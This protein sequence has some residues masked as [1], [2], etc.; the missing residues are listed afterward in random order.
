MVS[1]GVA[2]A[3]ACGAL[4]VP[5]PTGPQPRGF[6]CGE[7][8]VGLS[9]EID[10]TSGLKSCARRCDTGCQA[11]ETCVGGVCRESCAISAD[12]DVREVLTACS[13]VED[14]GV[15]LPV[16]CSGLRAVCGAGFACTSG[17]VGELACQPRDVTPGACLKQ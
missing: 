14:A 10:F 12:C 13:R 16:M 17:D 4:S 6:P 5:A 1:V 8:Q 2:V 3:L 7:C 9:C 15:C 11:D